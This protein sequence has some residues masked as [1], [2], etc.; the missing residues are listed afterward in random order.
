MRTRF[1]TIKNCIIFHILKNPKATL[2]TGIII[3]LLSI[4]S[5][6]KFQADYT[7]RIWFS[8]ESKEIQ[9]L[10][11]FEK[12]FGGDQFIILG[13]YSKKGILNSSVLEVLKKITE[14]MWQ[15]PDVVRV[16]SLTNFNHISSV[17]DDINIDPLVDEQYQIDEVKRKVEETQELESVLISKNYKYAMVYIKLKPLLDSKTNFS[18]I[19]AELSNKLKKFQDKDIR[20]LS[21]GNVSVTDAFRKIS[22]S[23][24]IK[25]IPFMFLFIILLLGLNFRSKAGILIPLIVSVFTIGTSF[26]LMTAL[27][28]VFNSVLAAIPGV[29]LAICLAD[30]VHILS[31]FYQKLDDDFSIHDALKYS[32]D[33]NFL[34]TVLTS[35]TTGISFVTISFTDLIPIRD[36]GILAAFGTVLAWINTYL[37]LPSLIMLFPQKYILR[38]PKTYDINNSKNKRYEFSTFIEKFKY[39][40]ILI[41]VTITIGS[42][43]LALQNEVNSDP[44]KY[45]AQD[46][47]LKSDYDFTKKHIDVIR[48]IELVID[49][50]SVDGVK[51]PLFLKTV[52]QFSLQLLKDTHIKKFKS[53]IDVIKKM[54][55]TLNS[56]DRNFYSIPTEK[57]QVAEALFLYTL[58][59]PPGLGIE[60]QVSL[61]NRY[62]NVNIKWDIENTKES[63]A[64]EKEIHKIAKS[65]GLKAKTGGFFPIYAQVN[66]KVVDSFFRS[67]SMA[68]ILVSIIILLTF[69]N[70]L[71]SFLAMLPNVIPLIFGA[72]YM[73]LNDIYIDIGTSIVSAICLGIAVD[74]TIHFITH[75]VA[76]TRKYKDTDVALNRTFASTGKALII[77]TVLLVAGF[78]SF[79]MADFLPNHYFGILCALVLSFALLTDILLLPAILVIWNKKKTC[80]KHTNKTGQILSRT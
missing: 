11:N 26:G 60:N 31:S 20:F 29:L 43:W 56:D 3:F 76:N 7:P 18:N 32:M 14:E 27:G 12:Q 70:P 72:A 1:N 44:L 64:K 33:K 65:L 71:L 59:L 69:K 6:F 37:F 45:F 61:D 22:I 17:E 63:I 80:V 46:T 51:D 49:S 62:L 58:G 2:W 23:D 34:A 53:I 8:E 21:L 25:T 19:T 55:Q 67:M 10:N 52:D 28:L 38:R 79:V 75:F 77:T 24:N 16:E 13:L 4:S 57:K 73:A 47:K 5:L 66:D 35:L 78:G 50:G 74:D 42:T 68:I 41:F 40:I 36:L 54:N 15:L 48:G 30:T 9:N 39:L